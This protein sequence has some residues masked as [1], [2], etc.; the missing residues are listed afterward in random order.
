MADVYGTW[1]DV[2]GSWLHTP[3]SG[4]DDIVV[5]GGPNFTT[6]VKNVLA[7]PSGFAMGVR[8][9]LSEDRSVIRIELNTLAVA[10]DATTEE[11]FPTIYAPSRDPAVIYRYRW[12]CYYRYTTWEAFSQKEAEDLPANAWSAETGHFLVER[13]QR[14]P[15]YW[16]PGWENTAPVNGSFPIFTSPFPPNITWIRIEIK[17]EGNIAV[18]P[19]YSFL[20]FNHLIPEFRPMAVRKSGNWRSLDHDSGFLNIRKSGS[21]QEIPKISE[22]DA[23][24]INQGSSRIRKS[25]NWRAQSKIG[26]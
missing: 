18:R 6:N 7:P 8:G 5:A 25:G 12:Y 10:I 11:A 19:V 3:N 13:Q 9:I 15:L 16:S 22:S 26:D 4:L 21:W 1:L 23:T 2:L 17:G 20:P 24:V 14:D